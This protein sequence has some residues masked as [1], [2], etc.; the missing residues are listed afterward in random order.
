M[1][2][3]IMQPYFFPYLGHF[4]IRTLFAHPQFNFRSAHCSPARTSRKSA[5]CCIVSQCSHVT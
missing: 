1:R 3:R 4:R 2:L 5:D